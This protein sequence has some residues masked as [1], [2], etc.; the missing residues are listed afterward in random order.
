VDANN[1]VEERK[2][3]I[4]M[5]TANDA[6]IL[7]GLNL[8]DRVVVSDRSGLKNGMQVKSQAVDVEQYKG[9]QQ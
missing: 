6:E 3:N 8:G 5:Q 2:I 9:T 4:G 7:S 1:A